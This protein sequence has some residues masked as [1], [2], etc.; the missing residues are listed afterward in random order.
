M[1]D[2][3]QRDQVREFASD[4]LDEAIKQRSDEFDRISVE[5]LALHGRFP[6][7][8]LRGDEGETRHAFIVPAGYVLRSYRDGPPAVAA[9]TDETVR[10][11]GRDGSV[12]GATS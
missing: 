5:V 11:L 9:R 3:T 7:V 8:V 12:G 2:E 4:L 6:A 10:K 1:L